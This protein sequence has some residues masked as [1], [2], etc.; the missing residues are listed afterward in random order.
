MTSIRYLNAILTILTVVL[1]VQLWTTW[2]AGPAWSDTAR[3]QGIPDGGAQRQQIVDQ[4][5]LVNKKVD[6]LQGL[7][8]SGKVRVRLAEAPEEPEPDRPRR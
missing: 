7:L 6:Q 4:L 2:T 8:T 3:A 1:G 5:K